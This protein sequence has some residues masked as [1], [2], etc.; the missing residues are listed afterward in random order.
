[1][2]NDRINSTPNDLTLLI[3]PK[4]NSNLTNNSCTSSYSTTDRHSFF[5]T[6]TP[7]SY[8]ADSTNYGSITPSNPFLRRQTVVRSSPSKVT[9]F[10]NA[11]NDYFVIIA[12]ASLSIFNGSL[13][14]EP[15]ESALEN[16]L[17]ALEGTLAKVYIKIPE[18]FFEKQAVKNFNSY[19]GLSGLIANTLLAIETLMQLLRHKHPVAYE[20]DLKP[21]LKSVFREITVNLAQNIKANFFSTLVKLLLTGA[22]VSVIVPFSFQQLRK[23]FINDKLP[24]NLKAVK[25]ILALFANIVA[26]ATYGNGWRNLPERY[27]KI[28]LENKDLRLW[29][30]HLSL[31]RDLLTAKDYKQELIKAYNEMVFN[32]FFAPYAKKNVTKL[33]DNLTPG[34]SHLF[35][36]HLDKRIQQADINPDI[37]ELLRKAI[38]LD[39]ELLKEVISHKFNSAFVPTEKLTPVQFIASFF[40]LNRATFLDYATFYSNFFPNYFELVREKLLEL[41]K[42]ANPNRSKLIEIARFAPPDIRED[43]KLLANSVSHEKVWHKINKLPDRDLER[44]IKY[45]L[46]NH[47]LLSKSTTQEILSPIGAFLSVLGSLPVAAAGFVTGDGMISALLGPDYKKLRCISG[48]FFSVTAVGGRAPLFGLSGMRLSNHFATNMPYNLKKLWQNIL[49]LWQTI[50]E[51]TRGKFS[52]ETG[53]ALTSIGYIVFQLIFCYLSAL[54]GVAFSPLGISGV[55]ATAFKSLGGIFEYLILP[56]VIF[57]FAGGLAVNFSSALQF[58]QKIFNILVEFFDTILKPF[59]HKILQPCGISFNLDRQYYWESMNFLEKETGKFI[60]NF[61]KLIK[62]AKNTESLEE[63]FILEESILFTTP[64]P[65][66]SP[67]ITYN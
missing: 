49:T 21:E 38:N 52:E 23:I 4:F 59:L 58:T 42:L 31:L 5:F 50:G 62:E 39:V 22:C 56:A 28:S 44:L 7:F 14:F 11:S 46:N 10:L 34:S 24:S 26:A 47:G 51:I 13:Y 12:A 41:S 1:M 36:N 48:L 18:E 57:A 40:E 30:D 60:K 33:L 45:L 32:S 16:L 54:M 35:K 20:N 37:K 55:C 29:K 15:G 63:T 6:G 65:P 64:E 43:D 9:Q 8:T 27:R 67:S 17:K 66:I 25:I 53:N 61:E 19:V 3:P 2:P